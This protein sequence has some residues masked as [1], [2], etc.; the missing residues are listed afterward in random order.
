MQSTETALY[1][2]TAVLTILWSV[3][4]YLL[5]SDKSALQEFSGRRFYLIAAP[6]GYFLLLALSGWQKAQMIRL[7]LVGIAAYDAVILISWLAL[8]IAR[9]LRLGEFK[10]AYVGILTFY[11]VLS[12]L[13]LAAVYLVRLFPPLLIRITAL[14]SQ[15]IH[16]EFFR[17]AWV[18]LDP[19]RHEQD[20]VSVANKALIAVISYIPVTI[21]RALYVNR[22][23]SR[24]RRE[25]G[26]EI[27]QLKRRV[28]D[29]ERKQKG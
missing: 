12:I 22:Q 19:T 13:L 10:R 27:E 4:T 20:L 18:G 5:W 25:L 2:G 29:L 3:W 6:S 7:D 28:G 16:L 24:H 26:D 21:F 15:G 8:L 17:F 14:L 9:A 23:M 1:I 11:N